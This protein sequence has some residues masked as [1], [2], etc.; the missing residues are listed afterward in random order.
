MAS[1]A[2]RSW[3]L[4]Q[5]GESETVEFKESFDE[6]AIES[7]AAFANARGG[8][9]LVGV[10]DAGAVSGVQL[11]KETLRD[12]ANRIAQSTRLNPRIIEAR[13]ERK[14]VVMVEVLESPAKP[15]PCRGRYFKRVGKANRQ[16]T[17]DD[18][19]R[20]VLDK[21]GITWDEMAE[22]R[23]ALSDLDEE[24]IGRFR[25]ACNK[26]K[27]RVISADVATA[28][29]LEK[30]GLLKAGRP[31]RAAVLLFA[32]EPQRWYPSAT[33]RIGRFRSE[34]IIVDDCVVG[35]TV[36]DQIDAAMG[37][38]R[39]HLQTRFEFHGTPAR[40]VVWEYP[41]RALREA[42]TNAVCHR[43]YLDVA[44]TQVR[45]HDDRL[46][47]I[48]PGGLH[49]PLSLESL[50]GTHISRPRNRKLAEMLYY[51]GGIEQWG[52]GTLEIIDSCREAGL[53]DPEFQEKQGGLWLTLPKDRP[54]EDPLRTLGLTDRQIAAVLRARKNGLIANAEYQ[55]LCGVSKRTAS[56][57][58]MELEAKG[59]LEKMGT[60]GKG[61]Y[62]QP[63]GSHAP[64]KKTQRGHKGAK[65]ATKGPKGATK[66]P[67]KGA[68]DA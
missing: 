8:T 25:A 40:D 17:D 32:K 27:R 10:T 56:R 11:G 13:S 58:L 34:S 61:T 60:T 50:R 46:M 23:A 22:P 15:V 37:Y 6:E 65:G 31:S 18:L 5:Q 48:N 51:A 49:P 7:V 3:D 44:Q 4:L 24:R 33:V 53:P 35:G 16:M 68:G 42:I 59:L 64:T 1:A 55:K 29:A 26:K 57:E 47:V 38:F 2:A 19:T 43:D 20:L 39:E 63:A 14:S 30:L 45:W 28:V 21:V 36:F 62:Y 54:A 9:L 66:G 67:S 41:L 12:W 52:G